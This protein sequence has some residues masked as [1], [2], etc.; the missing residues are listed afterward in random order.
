[1][2]KV[3][4]AS[5]P[6]LLNIRSMPVNTALQFSTDVNDPVVFNQDFCRFELA[7]KGFL[8][9]NS[10][11]VV[12]V[13]HDGAT[14]AFPYINVGMFS[15]IQRAVL[16][17][18]SGITICS[19]EDLNQMMGCESMFLA[20]SV[21]K[22]REQYKTGRQIAYESVYVGGVAT[23]RDAQTDANGYSISNGKEYNEDAT[24]GTGGGTGNHEVGRSVQDCILSE[25]ESTFSLPLNSLFPYLQSGNQLPLFIMPT[26]VL[27][28][29]W[30]S[31]VGGARL[32]APK[33]GGIINHEIKQPQLFADYLF[34]SGE[35]MEQYKNKN[36]NLT[37]N[38]VDYRLSKNSQTK[39]Q[40]SSS[41]RNI[42]GNGMVVSKVIAG[43][44]HSH[45]EPHK[46]L[47][48][49]Y[50]AKSPAFN[51]VLTKQ[52]DPLKSNLFVNSRFLYPQTVSNPAT[53]FHH[54]IGAQGSPAFVSRDQ[55]S[56]E[57]GGLSSLNLGKYESKEPSVDIRGT[58]FWQGFKLLG[59]DRV[60]SRGI[61]L[62]MDMPTADSVHTQRAWL[63][64]LRYA[65][66]IDGEFNCYFA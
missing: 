50:N 23:S 26:V 40:A 28:I 60:D 3:D 66:L 29:Y 11:L 48:G 65:T 25:H 30:Q 2:S 8:H 51:A 53:H 49:A 59:V 52:R 20:N 64:V 15:L 31:G 63:E 6:A 54:L 10:Q 12:S 47:I 41:V 16:K 38:Y 55:Y 61:D 14:R 34:Y 7:P 21:N 4:P 39:A 37:F 13:K 19:T 5:A 45:A 18:A 62:H 17:T 36:R 58:Q 57:A 42:G 22:E 33:A 9:P 43:Y 32:S 56:G 1:M 24:H 44:E 27:E 46:H 35:F